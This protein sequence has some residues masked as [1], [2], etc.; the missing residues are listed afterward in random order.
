M[1][2]YSNPKKALSPRLEQV[3]K[4]LGANIKRARIRRGITQEEFALRTGTSRPTVRRLEA[5]K[6]TVSLAILA[7]ALE[8]LGLEGQLEQ[9]ADPD[10]DT[11][12]KALEEAQL[13]TRARGRNSEGL[14]F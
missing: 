6:A 11:L 2:K 3:L 1:S 8:L 12:G 7:Q 13:P 10:A 4:I 5:G 9:L 14:D